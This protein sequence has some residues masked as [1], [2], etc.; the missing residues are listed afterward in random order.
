LSVAHRPAAPPRELEDLTA[1]EL[2][3]LRLVAAGRTNQKIA[4]LLVISPLTAKTHVSHILTK[5]GCRDRAQLVTL[6]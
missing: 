4:G 5:L 1:R 2:E 3:I 6:A